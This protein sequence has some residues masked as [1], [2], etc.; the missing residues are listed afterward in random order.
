MKVVLYWIMC[1]LLVRRWRKLI[2]MLK[3]AE[4]II[5]AQAPEVEAYSRDERVR[6]W[7][8][9]TEPNSGDYLIS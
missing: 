4:K 7:V 2:R 9:I 6:K 8:F 5:T 3:E 1:H